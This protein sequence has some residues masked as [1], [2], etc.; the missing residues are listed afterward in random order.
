MLTHIFHHEYVMPFLL[1]NRFIRTQPPTAGFSPTKLGK[2]A[3]QLFITPHDMMF[4]L[5]LIKQVR[6]DQSKDAELLVLGTQFYA[7][8]TQKDD[9]L[10]LGILKAWIG[11]ATMETILTYYAK[12]AV[13]DIFRLTHELERDLDICAS[14]AAYLGRHSQ[15]HAEYFLNLSQQ[16]HY[17]AL[18]TKHGVKSDLLQLMEALPKLSRN[19]GRLLAQ[20]GYITIQQ[21]LTANVRTI[22][23]KTNIPAKALTN[24]M[25]ILGPEEKSTSSGQK[26]LSAY[27]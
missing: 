17:L 11:E 4:V 18:R 27:F 15:H 23:Q 6:S 7:N 13:G 21:V 2:L 14:V 5:D 3:I 1:T 16:F 26:R 8:H 20:A 19:R 24:I 25:T 9:P 22:S 10:V 12:Y